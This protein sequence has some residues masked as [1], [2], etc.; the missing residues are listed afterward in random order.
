M[1]GLR[2]GER[3][4]IFAEEE[5]APGPDARRR[6]GG[7]ALAPCIQLGSFNSGTWQD[8]DE[9]LSWYAHFRLPSLNKMPGCIAIRKLV[10][11]LGLGEARR[12]LRV[13]VPRRAQQ[14]VPC[15]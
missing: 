11:C 10:V 4:N 7:V 14:A 2:V 1:L 5:R 6:E 9:L 15:T 12:A 8:E 13:H 3:R